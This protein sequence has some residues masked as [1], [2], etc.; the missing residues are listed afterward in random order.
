MKVLILSLPL[1]FISYFCQSQISMI[2]EVGII[3][4]NMN[5]G[6]DN[7]SQDFN[8]SYMNSIYFSLITK[9][10]LSKRAM[11]TLEAR[12]LTENIQ[13]DENRPKLNRPILSFS[14]QI[15]YKIL[16]IL[17]IYYKLNIGHL[18]GESI[19]SSDNNSIDN[20]N[21]A[22]DISMPVG[23]RLIFKKFQISMSYNQDNIDSNDNQKEQ[24]D[25]SQINY[26]RYFKLG[27]GYQLM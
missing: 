25:G 27:I 18:L 21:S 4:S 5:P 3:Q 12:L 13:K 20:Y 19:L 9:Y 26:H 15:E 17:S 8:F 10:S 11:V 24:I 1:L 14:P 22:N 16:D 7:F 2:G 23:I 6:K